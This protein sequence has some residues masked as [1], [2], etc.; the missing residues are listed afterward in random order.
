MPVDTHSLRYFYGELYFLNLLGHIAMSAAIAGVTTPDERRE[1][2][3]QAI[4]DAG[5]ADEMLPASKSGVV[6]TL[7]ERWARFYGQ[8]FYPIEEDQPVET[9]DDSQE[10]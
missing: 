8:P 10:P 5:R 9:C 7:S 4:I 2:I 3:R 6:E 1:R